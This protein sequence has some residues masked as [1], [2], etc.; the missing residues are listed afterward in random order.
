VKWLLVLLVLLACGLVAAALSVPTNAAV[1]NGSAIS[2]QQLNSDVSAIADSPYYQC[3][4]NSETYLASNGSQQLP[5]VQGAGKGQN[6]GDNPTATSAFVATYLDT[7]IGHELV[8]Q[9]AAKRDVTVTQAQQAGARTALSNQ[10][11]SVMQQ[12]SQTA[13]GQNPKFS[14]GPRAAPLTG[15]EVLGQ[16]P[17]SF[18]DSQAQ[19]VATATALQ[20]SVAGVGSSESDLVRYYTRHRS[21]FDTVCFNGAAYSS[22]SDA[23]SAAASVASGTPFDQVAANAVQHGTIPCNLLTS[24]AGELGVSPSSLDHLTPGKVSEPI[25]VNGGYLLLELSSRT[26]TP[27]DK[28]KPVVSQAAQAAGSQVAQQAVTAAERRAS[29][30]VDPRYGTWVPVTASVFT[31]FTPKV[32]DV[33]NPGANEAAV[34]SSPS[35]NP[36]IPSSG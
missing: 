9:V 1:V 34:S 35:S 29:V 14:C 4:L 15:E 13:Q 28:A 20:E 24:L 25:N 22:E 2:Q 12:V 30:K 8:L 31:P 23:A 16:L 18:V 32:S 36:S 27:F 26:P 17:A 21:E 7:E 3:Y 33:L 6:P 11:S 19:F 10:I 5:P